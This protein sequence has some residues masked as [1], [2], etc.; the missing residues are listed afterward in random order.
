MDWSSKNWISNFNFCNSNT[1]VSSEKCLFDKTKSPLNPLLLN[2]EDKDNIT[3]Q[4][5]KVLWVHCRERRH[6]RGTAGDAAFQL[7]IAVHKLASQAM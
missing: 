1:I 5:A 2:V 3:F 4:M 6:H 7:E